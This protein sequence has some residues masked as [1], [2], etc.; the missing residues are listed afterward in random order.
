[1]IFKTA[2]LLPDCRTER[3]QGK[4]GS[5][6]LSKVTDQLLAQDVECA[7]IADAAC[8]CIGAL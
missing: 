4:Q 6:D 5:L 3:G 1:M 2:S 7:V 8:P